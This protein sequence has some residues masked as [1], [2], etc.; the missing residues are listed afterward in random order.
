MRDD[1]FPTY[2]TSCGVVNDVIP[3]LLL[4]VKDL[5]SANAQ[6]RRQNS[7]LRGE[8]NDQRSLSPFA[9]Q[10]QQVF[11]HWSQQLSPNAREF[12]TKRFDA[13][14][15]RLEKGYTVDDL[16]QAVDGCARKPYVTDSGRQESGQP[17]ERQVELELICRSPGNVDRFKTYAEQPVSNV[18]ELPLPQRHRDAT[19]PFQRPLDRAIVALRREFGFDAVW[20]AADRQEW[21]S[22]CPLQPSQATP[23]RLTERR[24]VGS[25]LEAAC[26]HGCLPS[27]LLEAVR[28]LE[29][30]RES[31]LVAV[32]VVR[33]VARETA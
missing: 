26:A 20:M 8:R 16:K 27:M 12:G 13:V 22:V 6:L 30:K 23:M 31:A 5:E 18:V 24:G 1:E 7:V 17:G 32:P 3:K 29:N 14:V 11:D 2:C 33:L 9:E 28:G 21:W 15:D 25:M 10:A 19:D 4:V